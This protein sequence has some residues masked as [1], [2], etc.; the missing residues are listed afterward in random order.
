MAV[1]AFTVYTDKEACERSNNYLCDGHGLP[2]AD[3]TNRYISNGHGKSTEPLGYKSPSNPV[4]ATAYMHAKR[5]NY[6]RQHTINPNRKKGCVSHIQFYVSPTEEDNVPPKE[7]LEMTLELIERTALKDFPSIYIAHDN[8]SQGHCHISL[9]PFSEDGS[10]KLCLNNKLL[11]D[12]RRQMDYICVEHGYSIIECPE[13]WGDKAYR[14][15]FFNI[16]EKGTVKIHPQKEHDKAIQNME[17]KRARNYARSKRVQTK[18]REAQEAYYRELT[19]GYSPETDAYF[20]TSPWLYNPTDPTQ[21]LRIKRIMDDGKAR[22]ELELHAASIGAWAYHCEQLLKNKSLSGTDK[23]RKQMHTIMKKT[24]AARQLMVD[25]DIRTLEELIIHIHE[26]GQD[27]GMLKRSIKNLDS[28]LEKLHP[29]MRSIGYWETEHDK[30]AR[31]ELKNNGMFC[32]SDIETAKQEYTLLLSKKQRY[33]ALLEDRSKEYRYLKESEKILNPASSKEAW[34][35]YLTSLFSKNVIN[36][37]KCFTLDQLES[38]IYELGSVLGLSEEA[39]DQYF[40]EISETPE[41]IRANNYQ[42]FRKHILR[43]KRIKSKGFE[44]YYTEMSV[45][46]DFVEMAEKLKGFGLLGILIFVVIDLFAELKQTG[47]Q[48]DLQIA[49]WEAKKEKEYADM[50]RRSYWDSAPYYPEVVDNLKEEKEKAGQQI[51]R[52]ISEF[53]FLDKENNREKQ[54]TALSVQSNTPIDFSKEE[55][56]MG[57]R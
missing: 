1:V 35:N 11:Y 55:Q 32:S 8:T 13:L 17:K 7:R 31:E 56:N 12:L 42:E 43:S 38:Q 4:L 23:L 49:L 47:A 29:I 26:C 10:H 9:C 24:Y 48:V 54:I 46:T 22:S 52:L 36:K 53:V 41:V 18:K 45:I 30:K 15:W 33:Q 19:K 21:P 25:L 28:E 57:I 6:E 39:L 14:E 20:F 44:K 16:K 37:A 2:E 34:E 3:R 51:Q 40:F 50:Y 27:I 5:W